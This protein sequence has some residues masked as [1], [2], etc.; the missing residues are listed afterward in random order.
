MDLERS[1]NIIKE[2]GLPYTTLLMIK[3]QHN[4]MADKDVVILLTIRLT[5][6][7]EFFFFR[8]PSYY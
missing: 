4:T 2:K 6:S 8:S 1:D 7:K 3:I 5:M